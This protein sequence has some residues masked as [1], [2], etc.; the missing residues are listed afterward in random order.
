MA[1][2]FPDAH[3]T[4]LGENY[5]MKVIDPV[6]GREIFNAKYPTFGHDIT[7]ASPKMIT[8]RVT[9]VDSSKFS[10]PAANVPWV[11]DGIWHLEVLPHIRGA[12]V[13]TIPHNMGKIPLFMA[14]GYAHVRRGAKMRYYRRDSDGELK[15]DVVLISTPPFSQYFDVG[16]MLNGVESPVPYPVSNYFERFYGVPDLQQATTPRLD[17]GRFYF[18]ADSTNIYVRMDLNAALLHE[19]VR[20]QWGGWN[21]YQKF[22]LDLTGSW[23]EFTFY[24]LPYTRGKDIFIR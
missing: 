9:F 16:P 20:E 11:V 10:E 24:I 3:Q 6:T 8:H 1:L 14:T 17:Y 13:A 22:W 23:Y 18:N 21:R 2:S 19:T 12:T 7:S 5:G 15:S 4:Y